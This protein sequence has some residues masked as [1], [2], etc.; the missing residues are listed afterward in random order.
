[1]DRLGPEGGGP[2]DDA[3]WP[4]HRGLDA[5]ARQGALLAHIGGY[6]Q[7]GPRSARR[8]YLGWAELPL[9]LRINHPS[10]NRGLQEAFQ[11]T[12]RV[13]GPPPATVPVG[14]IVG[15]VRY[16]SG[17]GRRAI[18]GIGGAHPDGRRWFVDTPTAIGL[19]RDYGHR[20][21][22]LSARGPRIVVAGR[23]RRYLRSVGDGSRRN[24]LRTLP[25]C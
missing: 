20:F 14:A 7:I 11:A 16:K 4:L 23:G 12:V 3:R 9:F 5:A 8:R 19:I 25:E 2:C 24:N 13:W 6:V 22:V 1:M 17:P 10:A 15:C 21:R 18:S